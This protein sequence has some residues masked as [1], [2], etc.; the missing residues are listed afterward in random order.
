MFKH[1]DVRKELSDT[2]SRKWTVPF[3]WKKLSKLSNVYHLN[4]NT[5]KPGLSFWDF[6]EERREKSADKWKKLVIVNFVIICTTSFTTSCERQKRWHLTRTD[7]CTIITHTNIM[8]NEGDMQYT[9]KEK[10]KQPQTAKHEEPSKLG[11]ISSNYLLRGSHRTMTSEQQHSIWITQE[12]M[13][14]K[15]IS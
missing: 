3:A 12:R 9:F 13:S 5:W 11:E 7:P 10:G 2:V 6:R 4:R 14:F 8:K 15:L 1:I